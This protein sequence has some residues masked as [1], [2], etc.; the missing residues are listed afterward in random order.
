MKD[1][2]SSPKFEANIT[3]DQLRYQK[4]QLGTLRIAVNNNT[5]NAFET[6][7]A[8]TGVHEL[9]VNGFYYTNTKNALDLTLNIDK[10]DLKAMESLS[11]GQIKRGSGTI[12]G[13]LSVKGAIAAPRVLGELKFNQAA[14]TA[15]YVNSYFRMPNETISFT[16]Q[17]I[18]F[19]DFT[20]LDSLG[21]KATISGGVLTTDYSNFRF[22][23]DISN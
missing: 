22:N 10:I 11:M 8:L 3:V 16:N 7:I 6:N 18:N 17:G 20:I 23:M 9:R 4:D 21:R 15:T 19:N 2:A 1:L 5:E 12:T 13:Q 14:F